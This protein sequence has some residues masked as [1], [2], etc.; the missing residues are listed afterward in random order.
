MRVV[1]VPVAMERLEKEAWF[2][3]RRAKL[4]VPAQLLLTAVILLPSVPG[5]CALFPQRWCGTS[6]RVA[7]ATLVCSFTSGSFAC[8]HL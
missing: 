1:L 3:A 5:G 2:A 8:S 7:H 6:F 4:N